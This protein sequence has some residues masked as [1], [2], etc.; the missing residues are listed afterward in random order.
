MADWY[1]KTGSYIIPAPDKLSY[2][3]YPQSDLV[4]LANFGISGKFISTSEKFTF[5]YDTMLQS[6]RQTMFENLIGYNAQK[7]FLK[8]DR[9]FVYRMGSK[10]RQM[11]AYLGAMSQEFMN[12]FMGDVSDNW[13]WGDIGFSVISASSFGSERYTLGG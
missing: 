5:N 11:E 6:D 2:E 3:L 7:A 1:F 8:G 4:R 9:K 10:V 13:V 12:N